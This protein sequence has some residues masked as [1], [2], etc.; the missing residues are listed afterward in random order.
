MRYP[1]LGHTGNMGIKGISLRVSWRCRHC[2]VHVDTFVTLP[3]PPTH[4]C[5]KRANR[6]IQLEKEEDK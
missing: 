4:K 2:G 3:E 5:P 1:P 6:N